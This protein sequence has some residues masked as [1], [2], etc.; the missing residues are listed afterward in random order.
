MTLKSVQIA[1]WL[2]DVNDN[3]ADLGP[4]GDVVGLGS[5]RVARFVFDAGIAA[6]R[7]AEAHG[8]GVTLPIHAIVVGGFIDV[9]T[10]FDSDATDAGTIAIS[11]QGAN[12]IIS[13]AAVSG[14][15]FST[16]G[17]KAI[18]PKAN[19][20][21]STSVKCTAARE[22]TCTVAIEPLLSGKLTGYLY[23]VEG[24]ASA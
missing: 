3:F 15:P 14:A 23:Y 4:V 6:N 7:T 22:I 16:V 11:V 10:K 12:D 1:G 2:K 19:T 9:N 5:L 24:I 8:T 13:A 21:E 18:V 17:R 20:P